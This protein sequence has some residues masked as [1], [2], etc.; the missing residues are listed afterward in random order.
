MLARRDI[1]RQLA[2]AP[3]AAGGLAAVLADPDAARAAASSLE[4]V[5]IATASGR[6]VSAAWGAPATG[7]APFVLL[8]HEWWGLN[9]YIKSVAADFVTQ[10]YGA[11]AI[12]LYNGDVAENRDAPPATRRLGLAEDLDRRFHGDRTGVVTFIDQGDFPATHFDQVETTPPCWRFQ[13]A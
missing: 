1:I 11:L 2:T 13:I 5:T 12:D 4:T 3:I 9:D 8:V 7:P 6:E 10:G